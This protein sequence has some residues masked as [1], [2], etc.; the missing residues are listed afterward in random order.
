MMKS[1]LHLK[2]RLLGMCRLQ[3]RLTQRDLAQ[4]EHQAHRLEKS[5]GQLMAIADDM[6][7][8]RD[9][10]HAGQL[11]N[12]LEFGH[13]LIALSRAQQGKLAEAETIAAAKRSAAHVSTLREERA[14]LNFRRARK[15]FDQRL[16]DAL[17]H[18]IRTNGIT[19]AEWKKGLFS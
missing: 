17:P 14:D 12:R 19:S 11:A 1:D 4:A 5:R 6:L 16:R 9:G 2:R 13:R 15:S 10:N 7:R 18:P 8:A 3:A